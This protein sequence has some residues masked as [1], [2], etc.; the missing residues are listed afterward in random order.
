MATPSPDFDPET[1]DPKAVAGYYQLLGIQPGADLVAVDRAYQH[2]RQ[3]A[4]AQ[5]DRSRLQALKQAH[6][7]VTAMLRYY[8]SDPSWANPADPR[9]PK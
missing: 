7:T 4:L 2:Q 6:D 8:F 5:H 1:L 3:E 9:S